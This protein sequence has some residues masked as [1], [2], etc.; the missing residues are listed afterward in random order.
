MP[1]LKR[2]QVEKYHSS[3]PLLLDNVGASAPDPD[4][5]GQDHIAVLRFAD[6]G[7]PQQGPGF[8]L[9]RNDVRVQRSHEQRVAQ[10]GET[11]VYF[12]AAV[13]CLRQVSIHAGPDRPAG[14]SVERHDV[15]RRLNGI[16]NA[17]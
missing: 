3:A 11:A 17:V 1:E 6:L 15:V 7:L 9:K 13:A 5:G 14:D 12:P 10:D 4:A 8:R 16:E 2:E